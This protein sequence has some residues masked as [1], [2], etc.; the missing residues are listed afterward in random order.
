MA[1][2]CIYDPLISISNPFTLTETIMYAPM[3]QQRGKEVYFSFDYE[4]VEPIKNDLK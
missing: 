1:H 4:Q 2:P 3:V